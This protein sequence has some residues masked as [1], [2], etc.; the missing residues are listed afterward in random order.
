MRVVLRL[1][2]RLFARQMRKGELLLI[3]FAVLLSVA[4][5]TSVN[6]LADRLDRTM[7]SE[8]GALIGGDLAITSGQPLPDPWRTAAGSM[9]IDTAVLID[10]SSV[11]V[12][13]DQLLLVSVRAVSPGYPLRGSIK[14]AGS[15][16]NSD[17]IAPGIPSPGTTWVDQQTIDRLGLQV[18]DSI[19]VGE[20]SLKVEHILSPETNRPISLG[21]FAPTILINMEDVEKTHVIQPG[22]RISHQMLFRG[23][24]ATI[25]NFKRWLEP[26]LNAGQ[27]LSDIREN[28]PEVGRLLSQTRLFLQLT[29]ALVVAM[30]G[31]AIALASLRHAKGQVA[32]AAILRCHG[33]SRFKVLQISLVEISLAALA[34]SFLGILL[35]NLL[36]AVLIQQSRGLFPEKLADPGTASW[37]V[38]LVSGLLT[39]LVFTQGPLVALGTLSPMRLLRDET[40]KSAS[41][42][43]SMPVVSVISLSLLVGFYTQ[44][45]KL[46]G[47]IIAAVVIGFALLSLGIAWV[48][49]RLKQLTPRQ[50][51]PL[52]LGIQHLSRRPLHGSVQVVAFS[53]SLITLMTLF[54][55]QG[56]LVDDWHQALP[57]HAPNFFA[58]NLFDEQL[59]RFSATLN[60]EGLA[61]SAFYPIVRGRLIKV[62][63]DDILL[64]VARDPR[65]EGS[66]NRELSL[67]SGNEL[68]PD[69]EVIAG[70]WPAK[71]E[72]VSVSMEVVLAQ[73][74]G[75]QIGDRLTFDIA[76]QSLEATVTSLR[77]LHWNQLTPNFFMFFEKGALDAFPRSWL[78][79]FH[80]PSQRK[81]ILAEMVKAFPGITLIDLRHVTDHIRQMIHQVGEAFAVLFWL[82]FIASV[83]VLLASVR[84]TLDDRIEEDLLL[85]ALGAPRRRLRLANAIEF[86]TIGFLAGLIAAIASEVMLAM[87]YQALMDIPAR[88]HGFLWVVGPI[89]GAA[90]IGTAGLWGTRSIT[91]VPPMRIFRNR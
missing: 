71:S 68:P 81:A 64:R 59:E 2:L 15:S 23:E 57:D 8:A 14:I 20:L 21:G 80:L 4:A 90:V 9:G 69:N 86:G 35:G 82:S 73:R 74:L 60:R 42:G 52:R 85:R 13:K 51:I 50:P 61:H 84:A 46:T 22:S 67:T 65:T 31:L 39:A 1:G 89:G 49:K 45:L 72:R 78:S 70:Q 53:L 5:T 79:S 83:M 11:L 17:D 30:T 16:A 44:D 88:A 62:N 29:S 47:I 77:S 26:Q 76:G 56:R 12:E 58:L 18:S 6:R 34:G 91:E 36:E 55:L 10:F 48:L 27:K 75:I 3:F 87:V 19:T 37:L 7:S 63:E 38:G 43:L 54:S 32:L 33:A 28:R 41:K 40:A 25:A 66:V 24:E